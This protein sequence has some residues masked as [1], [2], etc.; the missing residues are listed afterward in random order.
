MLIPNGLR[1]RAV[2]VAAGAVLAAGLLAGIGPA[3]AGV[4]ADGPAVPEPGQ[5]SLLNG[6]FCTSWDNCWAVGQDGAADAPNLNEIL[7][8]NGKAWTPVKVASP[9]G[10]AASDDSELYSVRCTSPGNC[11][12]VG[13]YQKHGADLDE[14]FHWNGRSWSQVPAP[15]PGGTLSEDVNELYSVVC[16]SPSSCWAT[17]YY[18]N[19][20]TGTDTYL[21]Q[22]LHWNG[23]AWSAV[24]VPDP[25]GTGEGDSQWLNSIRCASARSCL[26]V[27]TYGDN[28][29]IEFRNLALR[30][31]GTRWSQLKVPSPAGSSI[32]GDINDLSGLGCT[33]ASDCWAVG[34]YGNFLP[35]AVILNEVLHWNG[36]KW[37]LTKA[38]EPGGSTG[39]AESELSEVSCLTATSCWAVGGYWSNGAELN[40][41]LEWN[42]AKWTLVG[43]PDPEGTASFDENV[44]S[45]VRCTS[46]S[47]CWAVGERLKKGSPDLN[48]A[49]H[50]NG[51]TWVNG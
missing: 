47:Q 18:G 21:D 6:D 30:W 23:T 17:G 40:Q 1:V 14:V 50:W 25:A 34:E 28:Q 5:S 38:P 10:S 22:I 48:E 24:P 36:T 26:A 29:A 39:G 49:L 37:S 7:H 4:L 9:G 41:A 32:H 3:A 45:A 35:G 16:P 33:A 15:T 8:W 46:V 27:G 19:S 20:A 43:T 42:G 2:A 13:F 12:A 44:L 31:N 51:R 11:W